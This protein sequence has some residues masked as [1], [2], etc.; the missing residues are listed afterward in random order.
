MWEREEGEGVNSGAN[1]DLIT[2]SQTV[3]I[4]AQSEFEWLS[5]SLTLTSLLLRNM[6]TLEHNYTLWHYRIQYNIS[7]LGKDTT[8]TLC[9]TFGVEASFFSLR[10][11]LLHSGWHTG[12]GTV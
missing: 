6:K 9:T 10:L 2:S 8:N 7:H 12:V 11:V 4:S 1:F 5:P 3:T